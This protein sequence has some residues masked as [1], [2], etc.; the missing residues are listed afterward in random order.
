MPVERENWCC[1]RWAS[2]G[3]YLSRRERFTAPSQVRE[4]YKERIYMLEI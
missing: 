3:V 4:R 2:D 1:F